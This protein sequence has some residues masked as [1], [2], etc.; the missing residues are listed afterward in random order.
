MKLLLKLPVAGLMRPLGAS[1]LPAVSDWSLAVA[2]ASPK[3]RKNMEYMHMDIE[4]NVFVEKS[5]RCR[6]Y[7][8]VLRSKRYPKLL[9]T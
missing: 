7:F 8:S 2:L 1:V 6:A 9:S 5:R 4:G 3:W